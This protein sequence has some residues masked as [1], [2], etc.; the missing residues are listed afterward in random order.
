MNR[1]AAS[2]V[3]GKRMEKR[4]D[5]AAAKK[6]P[7]HTRTHTKNLRAALAYDTKIKA[8]KNSNKG[9]ASLPATRSA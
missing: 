9:E 8:P 6:T 5:D 4:C 7:K 3:A 1:G 2:S